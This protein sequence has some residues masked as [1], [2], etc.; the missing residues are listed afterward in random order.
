MVKKLIASDYDG[1]FRHG[2]IS[3]YN[4]EMIRKWREKGNYFGIVTGRGMNFFNDVREDG[5]DDILDYLIIYNGAYIS[6]MDGNVLYESFIP[7]SVFV[8]LEKLFSGYKEIKNYDKATDAEFYHQYY[9]E[10]P[11]YEKALEAAKVANEKFGH[12][13]DAFVNGPHVNIAKLGSSKAESVKFILEHYGLKPEEGAVVGDDYNDLDMIKQHHG[14]AMASGKPAVIA[15][16]EHT[17]ESV[18]ALAEELMKQN[19]E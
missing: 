6:D 19:A 12:K 8:E 11:D 15:E 10:F 7:R 5:I 13:I 3:D 2:G 9:A 18:G 17:C 14:W 16:A 4:K 1:T